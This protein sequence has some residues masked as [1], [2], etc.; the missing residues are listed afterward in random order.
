MVPVFFTDKYIC[1]SYFYQAC[2]VTT[3]PVPTTP[4]LKRCRNKDDK[5]SKPTVWADT[6]TSCE[7]SHRLRAMGPLLISSGIFGHYHQ[8]CSIWIF[9][10][11]VMKE[12]DASMCNWVWV[13]DISKGGE[14]AELHCLSFSFLHVL[15]LT[16]HRWGETFS[17]VFLIS[18]SKIHTSLLTCSLL[19]GHMYA[20][21]LPGLIF[22]HK[23]WVWW[24]ETWAGLGFAFSWVKAVLVTLC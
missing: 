11:T 19:I 15:K 9:L 8:T 14:L 5:M 6:V 21:Y 1:N 12:K 24:F 3:A 17:P 22:V 2:H 7:G 13:L 4:C 23:S 18:G 16:Y 20:R 10:H